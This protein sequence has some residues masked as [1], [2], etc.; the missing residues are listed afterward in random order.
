MN[1]VGAY[2][3]NIEEKTLNNAYYRRVLYT[4]SKMQLVVMS[5]IPGEDIPYEVHEGSQFIRVEEGQAEVIVDGIIHDLYKDDIIIIDPGK[6]HY[7]RNSGSTNLKLY[8]I[9][10]PPEHDSTEINVRQ[11]RE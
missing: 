10:T 7:V 5:L 8:S 3:T 9:Y 11:P 1:N 6:W 2:Y 4:N